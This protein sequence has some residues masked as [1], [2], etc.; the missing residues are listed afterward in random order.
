MVYF[1]HSELVENYRVS[2]KTIHNWIDAA[3]QGKVDLRLHQENGKTYIAN[4]PGNVAILENLANKGKKYRNTRHQKIITP[5]PE[6]YDLFS[7][8]Q[9]LDIIHNLNIHKE[10][11][12]QYNYFNGGA[13]NWDN[14]LKRLEVDA[15]PNILKNTIELMHNNLGAIDY[16]LTDYKRVNV[17]DIGVG[18][19]MPTK[20][21]LAHLVDRGVLHRYIAIDISQE[22][23][24]IAERNVKQWFGDKVRFEGHI[25]DISY[26]RFDDVLID[27]MLGSEAEQTVNLMLLLGATPNNFLNPSDVLKTVY[28]SM[29]NN[30]LLVYTD[31]Y[32]TEASRRYFDFSATPGTSPLSANHS[33]MPEILNI[34]PSLYDV[35]MGFNEQKR[36][37]Y[38]RLRLKTAVII[39]FHFEDSERNVELEKG[40]TILLLRVWHKTAVENISDFEKTGFKLL[41]ASMTRD[42]QF[43]LTISGVDPRIEY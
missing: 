39:N 37:R 40:D 10:I 35:E 1:K 14:W 36:M 26:E 41:Q 30:D 19:A 4:S 31:K 21:L 2:L 6:F 11:P 5:K 17:I 42:R 3:K 32:D 22:M 8:R 7:R 33:F 34:D 29:G 24:D 20:D 28:G 16:L 27:D 25:R 15:T 18:N 23:L 12:R 43:M 13:T 38:I 9:I